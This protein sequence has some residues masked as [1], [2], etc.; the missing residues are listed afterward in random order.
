MFLPQ[1]LLFAVLSV[2]GISATAKSSSS[3]SSARRNRYTSSSDF[4]LTA[5]AYEVSSTN[6]PKTPMSMEEYGIH[7]VATM[8]QNRPAHAHAAICIN[9]RWNVKNYDN[10]SPAMTVAYFKKALF[11]KKIVLWDCLYIWG[12]GQQFYSFDDVKTDR[13]AWALDETKCSMDNVT[14]DVSCL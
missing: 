10:F 12:P 5:Y 7:N 9:S 1:P 2:F 4:W 11:K 14:M 13:M 3:S 6:W 8:W